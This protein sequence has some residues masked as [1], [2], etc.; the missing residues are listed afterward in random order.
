MRAFLWH[1][2]GGPDYMLGLGIDMQGVRVVFVSGGITQ[3][4]SGLR[5]LDPATC[6]GLYVDDGFNGTIYVGKVVSLMRPRDVTR[7]TSTFAHEFKHHLDRLRCRQRGFPGLP[8]AISEVNAEAF[9][10][11]VR[12]HIMTWCGSFQGEHP[13]CGGYEQWAAEVEQS[14]AC[15]RTYFRRLSGNECEFGVDGCG[16]SLKRRYPACP[17]RTSKPPCPHDA[18]VNQL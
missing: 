16:P 5:R 10:L 8:D 12:M 2:L 1:V 6:C 4:G 3:F 14:K 11:R 7:A 15:L 9:A 18:T 17:T 13:I